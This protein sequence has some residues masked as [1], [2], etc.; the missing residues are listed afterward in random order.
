MQ[1][2]TDKT[3]ANDL[4]QINI[5][6][7]YADYVNKAIGSSVKLLT[8]KEFIDITGFEVD[9]KTFD[10]L[11]MNINDEGV[12][13]YINADMLNWMGYTGEEKTQLLSIKKHM[14]RNFDESDYKLLK[15]TEYKTFI[16]DEIKGSHMATLNFP[17]PATGASARSKTHLIVMPE[18]F[19]HLCMMIN[20]NKGKQIRKYY[21]TLEKLIKSYNLYQTMFRCREAEYAMSCKGDKIDNLILE[22]KE[23]EKK[24]DERFQEEKK[25]AKKLRKKAEKR[26]QE[27]R[28]K[29]DERFNRLLG[30]AEDT[31][32]EVLEKISE[33]AETRLDLSNV[34]H[35][36]VSI[37]RVPDNRYEYLVILK[38]TD[39]DLVPYYAL[40]AQKKSVS[41]KIIKM[42][43][44]YNVQEVFRIYEPNAVNFWITVC[45]KFSSNI[46]KSTSNWFALHNITENNFKQLVTEMDESERKNP[47]Y[48]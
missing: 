42:Q 4:S 38:D 15:N 7:C 47:K 26:F 8:M 23:N 19:R 10:I 40:R 12:P 16:K 37:K 11:F 21:T 44:D 18:A 46:R 24:A 33:L 9:S 20:T 39:D 31:K 36:R 45:D 3:Q 30:V 5:P 13:I 35:D 1:F 17:E 22:I 34:V 2:I 25:K 6:K 32:E 14:E 43:K 48:I 27:E 29:S 41:R 28:K